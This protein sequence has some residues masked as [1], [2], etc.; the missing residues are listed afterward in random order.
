MKKV[1]TYENDKR[2]SET[3][4]ENGVKAILIEYKDDKKIIHI[5]DEDKEINVFEEAIE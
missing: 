5:F 4:Y 2:T 3:I 1:Y